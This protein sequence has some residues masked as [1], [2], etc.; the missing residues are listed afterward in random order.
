MFR[1]L[2]KFV[3]VAVV[4]ALVGAAIGVGL[5]ALT[6]SGDGTDRVRPD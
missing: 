2:G 3:A 5:A 1:G 6:D 4:A